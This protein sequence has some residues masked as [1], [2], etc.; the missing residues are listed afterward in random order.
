M[1]SFQVELR[2]MATGVLSVFDVKDWFSKKKGELVRDIPA[3]E[4]RQIMVSSMFTVVLR[5]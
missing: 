2:N 3:R 1:Y 5:L 4:G